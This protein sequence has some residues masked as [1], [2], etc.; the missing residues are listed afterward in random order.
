MK[1][2]R[3]EFLTT[4]AAAP[5][6]SPILLGMQD[7]AGTRAPVVGEG[8]YTYEAIHDWGE[9]PP[10]IKWGNTHG[11]VED[12]QGN[13]HIHHTVHQTSQS[14]DTVVVFD[15]NGRFVRSWGRQVRGVAHGIHLQKE[16]SE[17][18]LYLTV[19]AANPKMTPQPELQACVIKATLTGDIVWTIQGPPDAAVYKAAADEKPKFYN[20]TNLAVAPNGDVY[21][22]DGYGSFYINQYTPKGEYIRSFGGR[23]SEAGQL[24]EPHGIWMDTRGAAPM[25]VVADRRNNRLQRFTLDGQ[26]VDFIGGFRLPCHFD[27][28]DGLL[29]VPDLHGRVSLVDRRNAVVAHLGDSGDP[30]WNN[31]LRRERREQFIPGR[32]ICPHGACFDSEGDI[33]VVE[34]VE[35]GRVTKL[36]R[37]S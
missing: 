4:A 34:W 6:V 10:H 35:V 14:A 32:F 37:V 17:E 1:T 36:R 29:V 26:H 18:F 22:G 12:A 2:T 5:L 7:K 21:V 19:T 16:G 28:H 33:F 13:L 30:N 15:R 9:L 25:L 8:A 23:G 24:L 11:V 27:E 3:R 20:P 31:P